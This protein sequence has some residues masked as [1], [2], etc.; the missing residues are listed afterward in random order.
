MYGP[1]PGRYGPPPGYPIAPPA[2]A[3]NGQ[4]LAGFG[5]R[6]AARLIDGLILGGFGIVLFIPLFIVINS[7]VNNIQV[8]DRG[9][10]T[11]AG[12]VFTTFLLLYGGWIV[13]LF[14][15]GYVYEVEMMYRSGQTLGKRAM[16][17]RV[18]PLQP[19]AP[20]TRGSAAK[21]WAVYQLV[22]AVVPM[23][24]LLDG[25]WQLWDKPFQQ[26]LHDKAAT[27]AVVK[28]AA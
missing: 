15:A 18:V 4:P 5:E 17:I 14:V 6:L 27:T 16:K 19:G 22:G 8:N 26:C 11:N 3:P 25:L 24:S 13:L 10:I 9:E 7:M 12:P 1:P 28:L 2:V 21:R 23:F 20:L